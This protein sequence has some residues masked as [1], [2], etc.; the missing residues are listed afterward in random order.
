MSKINELTTS[1]TKSYYLIYKPMCEK[2]ESYIPKWITPNMISITS[3]LLVTVLYLTKTYYNPYILS[4]CIVIY[5]LLDN[6]D[7][8]HARNTHQTSTLGEIIDHS[9]D[10]Y[11]YILFTYMFF[12]LYRIPIDTTFIILATLAFNLKHLLLLLKAST[13]KFSE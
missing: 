3:L 7:G 2:I 10:M 4:F 13:F 8:I 11:Y 12:N 5:W 6:L 1:N 9:G